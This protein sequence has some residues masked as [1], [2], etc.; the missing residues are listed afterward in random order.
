MAEHQASVCPNKPLA[1]GCSFHEVDCKRECVSLL[2]AR[3][4]KRLALIEQESKAL[5]ESVVQCKRENESL[6]QEVAES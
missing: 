2:E 5:R 4:N 6:K 1:V 3:M